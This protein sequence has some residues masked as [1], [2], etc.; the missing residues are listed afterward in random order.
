MTSK[1]GLKKYNCKLLAY[2]LLTVVCYSNS[3]APIFKSKKYDNTK[4]ENSV[5]FFV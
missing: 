2:E 1:L 5:N 3:E 4:E